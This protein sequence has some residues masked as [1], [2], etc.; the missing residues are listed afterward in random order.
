MMYTFMHDK[1]HAFDRNAAVSP[2]SPPGRHTLSWGAGPARDGH[3]LRRGLECAKDSLSSRLP[4]QTV[5][6]ALKG[7]LEEGLSA[8]RHRPPGPAPNLER[9]GQITQ[10]LASLLGESRT[11]TAAQ[12]AEALRKEGFA[13]STRSTRRYLKAMGAGWRRHGESPVAQAGRRAVDRA[14]SPTLRA[15]KRPLAGDW[16]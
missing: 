16:S 9:K 14:T 7:F 1:D 5:R 8:L 4:F 3:A 15:Q 6:L 11:W 10:V 2:G 13:L 12:L